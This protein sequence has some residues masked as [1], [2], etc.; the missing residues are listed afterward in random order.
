VRLNDFSGLVKPVLFTARSGATIS[1]H[2]WAAR[3]GPAS[4]PGIVITNGSVRADEHL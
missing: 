2:V 1:G 3:S 4:R